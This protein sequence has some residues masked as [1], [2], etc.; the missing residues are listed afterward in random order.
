MTKI[1]IYSS[2]FFLKFLT[3]KSGCVLW[4]GASYRPGSTII[5]KISLAFILSFATEMAKRHFLILNVSMS[6]M[7]PASYWF[8]RP[9]LDYMME[10]QMMNELLV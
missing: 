1:K 6:N 9:V 10:N 5:L 4:A 7:L 8:S 3:K 2:L